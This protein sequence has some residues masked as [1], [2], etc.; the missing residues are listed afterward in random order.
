MGRV[1]Q[2]CWKI[3]TSRRSWIQR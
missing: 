1:Y 3:Q 2:N